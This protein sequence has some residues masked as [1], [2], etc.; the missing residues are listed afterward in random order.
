LLIVRVYVNDRPIDQIH[1]QNVGRLEGENRQYRVRKPD[2]G[3]PLL[4]HH[5]PDPW[6]VLVGQVC[7]ELEAKG[8]LKPEEETG[9]ESF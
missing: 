5:R 8:Y 4:T 6:Y 3:L 1:I 9:L 7:R 2:L